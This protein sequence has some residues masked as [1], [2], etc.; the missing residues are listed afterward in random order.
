MRDILRWKPRMPANLDGSGVE[1]VLVS[2]MYAIIGAI[3]LQRGADV[4]GQVARERI[5]KPL[6]IE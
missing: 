2:S 3:A 6:G 5:L 1:V 4:A